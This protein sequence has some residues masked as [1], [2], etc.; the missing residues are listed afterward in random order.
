MPK[1]LNPM[2]DEN[3]EN[4]AATVQ[5]YNLKAGASF[6]SLGHLCQRHQLDAR[7]V[8]AICTDLQIEPLSID[9]VPFLLGPQADRLSERIAEIRK[10]IAEGKEITLADLGVKVPE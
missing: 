4:T 5:I 3:E 8:M 2:S 9:E 10:M 6:W 1:G 7:I